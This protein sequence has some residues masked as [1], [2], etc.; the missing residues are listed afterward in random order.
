MNS[1][2]THLHSYLCLGSTSSEVGSYSNQVNAKLDSGYSYAP[3]TLSHSPQG[4]RGYPFF[5][6]NRT[7]SPD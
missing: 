2:I 3:D 1:I 7:L 6:T 4:R 5:T